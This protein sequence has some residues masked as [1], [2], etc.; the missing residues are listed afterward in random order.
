[1]GMDAGS[2]VGGTMVE[3]ISPECEDPE[4]QDK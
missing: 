3:S 1:M 2:D 4:L